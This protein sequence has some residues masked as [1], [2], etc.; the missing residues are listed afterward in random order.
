MA[1]TKRAL[2]PPVHCAGVFSLITPFVANLNTVYTVDAVE[3]F[4]ELKADRVDIYVRYY[5]PKGL[6]VNDYTV[7]EKLNASIVTLRAGDGSLI[8]VPDTYIASYPGDSGAEHQHLVIIADLGLIPAYMDVNYLTSEVKDVLT[9][10]V[11]VLSDVYLA[12]APVNTQLTYS[13]HIDSE[14]RRRGNVSAYMSK[15]EQIAML[16]SQV[17]SLRKQCDQLEQLV[18]AAQPTG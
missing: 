5:Q 17:E 18:I 2:T 12:V 15:D 9:K 7:D 3:T 1:Q 13:Q 10:N 11:G 14:R 6:T 8:E 16:T 4:R